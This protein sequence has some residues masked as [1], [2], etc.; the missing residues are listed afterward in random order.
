MKNYLNYLID[1]L[2]NGFLPAFF[3]YDDVGSKLYQERIQKPDYYLYQKEYEIINM[4]AQYFYGDKMLDMGS[5]VTNK[6]EPIKKNYNEYWS[7]DIDE[8]SARASSDKY[9]VGNFLEFKNDANFDVFFMGSTVSNISLN[10][11]ETLIKNCKNI[12]IA[13]DFA[14]DVDIMIRAYTDK[15]GVGEAME[16]NGLT[17]INRWFGTQFEPESMIYECVWN[18]ITF[19]VETNLIF[20]KNT[21]I[22]LSNKHYKYNIGDKIRIGQLRKFMKHQWLYIFNQFGTVTD[23]YVDA[24]D[25]YGIFKI[26][27]R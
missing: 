27:S 7:F 15:D 25:S 12:I 23:V 14:K 17:N 26:T 24:E 16:K 11:I 5:G 6:M 10:D 21:N 13:A 3:L 9:M 8:K 4:Y 19:I 2:D 18:P 20:T 22:V 1:G